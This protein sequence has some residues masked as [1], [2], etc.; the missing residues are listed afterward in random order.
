MKTVSKLMNSDHLAETSSLW[1]NWK[2]PKRAKNQNPLFLLMQPSDNE[3]LIIKYI[4]FI[5]MRFTPSKWW[6]LFWFCDGWASAWA[7]I[8]VRS[9]MSN[10]R[11]PKK[12]FRFMVPEIEH[13]V[14]LLYRLYHHQMVWPFALISLKTSTGI[15]QV[16]LGFEFNLSQDPQ[17]EWRENNDR[18]TYR[19]A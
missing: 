3:Q 9:A 1:I 2:R 11:T 14:T 10:T 15:W 16:Y 7:H 5:R 8:K 18:A 6:S 4:P 17:I 12:K 19:C 13:G